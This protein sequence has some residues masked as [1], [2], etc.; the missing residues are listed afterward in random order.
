M[1]KAS[2]VVAAVNAGKLPST[3]QFN[4]FLD[5]LNDVGIAKVEPSANS[6]LSSQGRVLANDLRGVLDAYKSLANNKN[7]DNTL[8]EAIWHL[9][10]GDL[11]TT[12]EAQ[13][14]KDQ[15]LQDLNKIRKSLRTLTTI[16]WS[17]Y[18]SEGS[19]LFSDFFSVLRTSLADAAEIVE[20][21]AGAAKESLRNIES[22]VQEGKRD[23]LGRDKQR[24]EEE[25]DAKVAWQHG[26]DT[27]KD[28]GTGIIGGVQTTSETIAEKSDQTS[29]RLQNAYSTVWERA[30]KDPEYREALETLFDLLQ[31]RLDQTIDAASDPNTTLSSFVAD[32]TPEQHIPKALEALKTVVERLAGTSLDPLIQKI[33]SCA[34]EVV[35]DQDLK[36]WFDEFFA[37][38]RKNL[39]ESGY[40]SS[41]EAQ[42]KR[43]ELRVRWR[44]LLE[45]DQKWQKAVD[46]VKVEWEKVEQG[47]KNDEDLNKLKEAHGKLGSDIESGLVEAG[48]EAQDKAKDAMQTVID[49]ATWFWQDLFRVY[50]PKFF[51]K[52]RDVPIPRTEY[53]DPDIEFVI[54]NLDISSFNILP[55]HV[56]IRNITDVDIQ[57]SANP[58]VPS[59]TQFGG[60]THIQL[61]AVQL[62]L[63]DVSFWY[64]DKQASS[65]QP[66][67]F[68]GLLGLTLPPKGIDIDLKIR[69]IP[70]SATGVHSRQHKKRFNTIETASVSISEDVQIDVRDSNHAV[71]V[72]LF[73]PIMV[74]RL[75][76][77]LQRTLTEQLRAVVSYF[78]GI[79]FDISKRQQVFKD[80]G[81]GSG[82]SLM[83]AM[84]SE[85]GRLERESREHGIETG[86]KATGTGIVVEQRMEV[87]GTGND[88]GEGKEI[89][90]TTF[91]MGA[92]PQIL[93]GEKRG[94][95][96]TGSE[97]LKDKLQR[98][99][100]EMGVDVESMQRS[101]SRMSVDV[102]ADAAQRAQEVLG[103]V[104]DKTQDFVQEGK[105]QVQGF[106]NS[107]E[108]KSE[109]EKQRSGWQSAAFDF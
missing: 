26:M 84:W 109:L 93:S 20:A 91:A 17:S 103:E 98:A 97:P 33:R 11:T 68:T 48:N 15:S 43:K 58:A 18:T 79:A 13:E 89:R 63:K 12:E 49:Q 52:M 41:D 71:F 6:G 66:G 87:P 59:K 25:K 105:R 100:E 50:V 67:E 55:S 82:A 10:Q 94:P 21:Q 39:G 70:E 96:G 38:S 36:A 77:A 74:S 85:I 72:T 23:T 102:P 35:R 73:R 57:T 104:K 27:V 37:F 1:D 62:E 99:G 75:R 16:M 78:D 65:V 90:K 106:K 51:A 45:K 101:D 47:L 64:K 42:A 2:S 4:A 88:L 76:E 19:A 107:V 44:T 32:P 29:S 81:L 95:L 30:Q 3:Q 46:E 9:S 83:G 56:Y 61:Q 22:E 54:E 92:E 40:S 24:L 108:R 31:K 28:A 69:L 80:T 60:L 7:E 86:W 14:T 34:N 8:Q 5:Y 53:K